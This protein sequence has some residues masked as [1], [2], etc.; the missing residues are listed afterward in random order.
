VPNDPQSPFVTS[1]IRIGTP[2]STTRGFKEPE[3]EAL[4]GWICD[5]LDN[6][7]DVSV[8]A[9]VRAKV[10]ALCRKFPVYEQ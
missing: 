6:L 1:G 8:R 5:I 9:T 2:A 3:V 7:G 4:T 10:E